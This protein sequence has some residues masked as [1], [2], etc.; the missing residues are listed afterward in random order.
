MR[1][2][3]SVLQGILARAALVFLRLFL[4]GIFLLAAWSKF[5]GTA[6]PA[7]TDLLA[8]APRETAFPFYQEL[9]EPVRSPAAVSSA[10][11]WAQLLL[12]TTL[13]LGLL[14]RLSAVLALVLAIHSVL[15]TGTLHEVGYGAI[16]IG[17]LIGAAGRT[18]GLDQL[19]ARRWP[20]SPL[21]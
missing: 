3:A 15:A 17:L 18:F 1:L 13:V 11:A 10:F 14:T 4:G 20:R 21:W 16:A 7:V 6:P 2:P 9:F 5:Q 12:G 19:L 8:A